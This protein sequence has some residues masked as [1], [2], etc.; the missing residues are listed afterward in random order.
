MYATS[1]GGL[2]ASAALRSLSMS[3]FIFSSVSRTVSPVTRRSPLHLY[4]NTSSVSHMSS[5]SEVAAGAAAAEPE[6]K[7]RRLLDAGGPIEDDETARQKMRDAKV[8][9]RGVRGTY[10]EYVGFDPDNVRDVKSWTGPGTIRRRWCSRQRRGSRRRWFGWHRRQM[11]L[12]RRHWDWLYPTDG[13]SSGRCGMG[14]T[15]CRR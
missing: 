4:K 7:R 2:A 8:Y 9:E 14:P 10:K 15:C 5:D 13:P 3:L 6:P 11:Q 12:G 1:R